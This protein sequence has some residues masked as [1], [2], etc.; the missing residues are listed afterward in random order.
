[1]ACEGSGDE[2]AG[3]SKTNARSCEVAF[4]V[5]ERITLLVLASGLSAML[6]S[7]DCGAGPAD[8]EVNQTVKPDSTPNKVH[9]GKAGEVAGRSD[10]D[11][12]PAGGTLPGGTV[13]GGTLPGGTLPGGTVQGGTL[14]NKTLPGGTVPGGTLPGGTLPGGTVP[15]GTI[16]SKKLPGEGP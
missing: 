13:P 12:T 5:M 9:S 8:S 4:A 1:M 16:P 10:L 7:P 6:M 15:G 11:N 14:P 2:T 3:R